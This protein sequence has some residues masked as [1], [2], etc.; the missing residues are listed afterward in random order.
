M[1]TLTCLSQAKRMRKKKKITKMNL[2]I[3]YQLNDQIKPR[4]KR[5]NLYLLMSWEELKI[6]SFIC[7]GQ[8]TIAEVVGLKHM[9]SIQL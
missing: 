4:K 3:N 6:G 5:L 8:K 7:Q 1:T 9:I 2:V